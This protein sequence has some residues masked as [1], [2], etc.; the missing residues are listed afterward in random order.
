MVLPPA[1]AAPPPTLPPSVEEAYRRKCIQLRHRMKTVEEANDASRIRLLRMRRGI[2]KMRLER[3]FLLEQLSKRTSTNVEDSDGSPSPPPTPKEKPLRTKRGRR[4]PDFL[5]D[6]PEAASGL[7]HGNGSR[8]ASFAGSANGRSASNPSN[9]AAADQSRS[10]QANGT[11]AP[12]QPRSGFDVFVK[13]MRSVLLVANRQKIK[14]GTYDVDQDLAR[15]WTNLGAKKQGD[16]CRRLEEGEYEGWEEVE[17][18]D[19]QELVEGD[20]TDRDADVAGEA[21]DVEMGE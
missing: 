5:Q 19:T 13:S 21:E 6:Q 16:Y 17:K 12:K 10:S 2:E 15:K 1:N 11:S 4:A 14:E 7:S 3:A 9:A 18:R 20:D 8:Q